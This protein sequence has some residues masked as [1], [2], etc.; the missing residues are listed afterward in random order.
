MGPEQLLPM[1]GAKVVGAATGEGQ[2]LIRRLL[3]KIADSMGADLNQSYLDYREKRR[4]NAEKVLKNGVKILG[5]RINNPGTIHPRV[6][7][8]I[9]DSGSWS[10]DEVSAHYYGGLLASSRSGIARDD[11]GVAMVEFI[12]SLSVYELRIHFLC[13]RAFWEVF[14]GF[15]TNPLKEGDLDAMLIY[16]PKDEAFGA[17]EFEDG[18]DDQM[19]FGASL[20]SLASKW[21]MGRPT[22]YGS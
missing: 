15:K 20:L 14:R 16:I 11:R 4:A 2:W 7:A 22:S 8:G 3:R 17:M 19:L 10:D 9:L 1:A 6:F 21:L 5:D 13:Y 12:K 18:E